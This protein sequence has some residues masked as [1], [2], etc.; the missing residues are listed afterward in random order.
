[1]EI[2]QLLCSRRCQLTQSQSHI[3]TDGQSVRQ[4]WPDIYYCLTVTV[5]LLWGAL[6]DERTGLSFVRCQLANNNLTHSSSLC[7]LGTD[8]TENSVFNIFSIVVFH[9]FPWEHVCLRRRYSVTATYTCLS[10]I[11]C[12]A[13]VLFHLLFLVHYLATGFYILQYIVVT[14]H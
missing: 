10:R 8:R 7:S 13:A 9:S 2:L 5:L 6:S 14:V 3:A 4:S 11:C 1:M 12:L